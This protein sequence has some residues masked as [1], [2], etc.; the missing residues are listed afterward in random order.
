MHSVLRLH[1]QFAMMG[2]YLYN[3][4]PPKKLSEGSV[5]RGSI[6]QFSEPRFDVFDLQSITGYLIITYT[7]EYKPSG[8][9][10]MLKSL[11]PVEIV[12]FSL[13]YSRT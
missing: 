10:M 13:V 12:K 2:A 5:K 3:N 9:M 6:S 1:Q 11:Q 4:L 8:Y 7:T